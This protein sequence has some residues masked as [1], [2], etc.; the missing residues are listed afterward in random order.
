MFKFCFVLL[1][2]DSLLQANLNRRIPYASVN[3]ENETSR[4]CHLRLEW[5]L[6]SRAF[7]E[8][9]LTN[10]ETLSKKIIDNFWMLFRF[11]SKFRLH[12]ISLT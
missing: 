12:E 6:N 2:L 1:C 9:K 10:I 5:L 11:Y 8:T 7:A 3:P 4:H